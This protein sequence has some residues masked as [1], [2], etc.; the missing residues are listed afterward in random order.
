MIPVAAVALLLSIPLLPGGQEKDVQSTR[1]LCVG[2]APQPWGPYET[3]GEIGA[4]HKAFAK[5]FCYDGAEHSELAEEDDQG[6]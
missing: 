4:P 6:D 5:T 1:V 2:V 3:I